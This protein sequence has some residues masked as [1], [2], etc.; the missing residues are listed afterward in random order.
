M[1]EKDCRSKFLTFDFILSNVDS[2]RWLDQ[3]GGKIINHLGLFSVFFF[4]YSVTLVFAPHHILAAVV[5]ASAGRSKKCRPTQPSP[6]MSPT[7]SSLTP[8]AAHSK[9]NGAQTLNNKRRSADAVRLRLNRVL[10][11][12]YRQARCEVRMDDRASKVQGYPRALQQP[13]RR[14][15]NPL[16]LSSSRARA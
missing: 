5:A 2:R 13:D 12:P 16:R 1:L 6:S 7:T 11:P 9:H 10:P 8:K 4:G 14:S 15:S 3:V